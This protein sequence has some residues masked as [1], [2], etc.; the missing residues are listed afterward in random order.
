MN[1]LGVVIVSYNGGKVLLDCLESL[2]F[3]DPGLRICVV[4]NASPDD[5]VAQLR[6]WADGSQPYEVPRD[7]P[8]AMETVARPIRL[9]EGGPDMAPDDS[10][11]I[12][13]IHS[14]RNLGY[15]GGV[16]IGL[17]HLHK[18]PGIAHFW[19][20]NPDSMVPAASI[21][22][23]RGCL[24]Q[25][26]TYGMLGGRVNY[27]EDPDV[28]QID[29]GIVNM[30]T[31]ITGNIHQGDSHSA[32][33]WPDEEQL[34]FITGASMVVSRTFY[35]RTGPMPEAYFLYYE[36]TDW[37]LQRGDLPLRYCP[38]FIVYHRAGTAIGSHTMTRVASPFALYFKHRNQIWFIRRFNPLSLW[39]AYG[40]ATAK[41][42][43]MLLKGH[44]A[45]AAAILRA[46][47]GMGPPAAVRDRISEDARELAFG[48][49]PR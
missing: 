24:S 16:N 9:T 49:R 34:D 33:V 31:G 10:A 14:G 5:T 26:G 44:K 42:G 37:A 35:D 36:E 15:A 23:L 40:Y 43:Q 2:L 46:V 28:I 7:C 3:A 1:D 47:N 30:G 45:Q 27:L 17:A 18:R 20:L 41:A 29:G 39:R 4:E 25:I 22:A 48:P 13:L 19:V 21:D 8:F 6:A 38:G 32:T 12:T 11:Q